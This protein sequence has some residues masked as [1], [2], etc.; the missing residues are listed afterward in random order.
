MFVVHRQFIHRPAYQ[1][2]FWVLRVTHEWPELKVWSALNY[3]HTTLMSIKVE[4]LFGSWRSSVKIVAGAL[5]RLNMVVAAYK[6][7]TFAK[8]SLLISTNGLR[9]RSGPR[10]LLCTSTLLDKLMAKLENQVL[11]FYYPITRL[12]DPAASHRDRKLQSNVS[13]PCM[14]LR[15]YMVSKR[16]WSIVKLAL[17]AWNLIVSLW[18]Y[19][20][21]VF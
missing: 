19:D 10:E 3:E 20:D 4:Y 17:L 1:S 18:C 7:V 13:W 15:C 21:L 9:Q 11:A 12:H 2:L 16:S 5:Y 8:G 14:R 6:K